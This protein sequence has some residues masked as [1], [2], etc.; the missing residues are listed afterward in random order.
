MTERAITRSTERVSFFHCQRSYE[1]TYIIF[2]IVAAAVVVL[3]TVY[4]RKQRKK[5]QDERARKLRIASGQEVEPEPVKRGRLRSWL[6]P[7]AVAPVVP[8]QLVERI[9]TAVPAAVDETL[10]HWHALHDAADKASAADEAALN[11]EVSGRVGT[12]YEKASA[13]PAGV[14]RNLAGQVL[15]ERRAQR[16]AL[17]QRE[18]YQQEL[19]AL[20]RSQ[21]RLQELLPT[22]YF[23]SML[24]ADLAAMV[25][26]AHLV[27]AE[28]Q[29]PKKHPCDPK[30]LR[31]LREPTESDSDAEL[32][33][34]LVMEAALDLSGAVHVLRQADLAVSA[35]YH[36]LVEARGEPALDQPDKP[37]DAEVQTWLNAALDWS[38]QSF[39]LEQPFVEGVAQLRS[40]MANAELR[41]QTLDSLA[42]AAGRLA[43]SRVEAQ[44]QA[45]A[46]AEPLTGQPAD[47]ALPPAP[48]PVKR[49]VEL[50]ELLTD[51]QWAQL[52]VAQGLM[53]YCT[54]WT[55]NIK[56]QLDA[57]WAKVPLHPFHQAEM[58]AAVAD[59]GGVTQIRAAMR[60]LGFAAAQLNSA[61]QK[62]AT[63]E[64]REPEAVELDP[65]SLDEVNVE[66]YV[67]SHRRWC[68]DQIA[69]ATAVEA[70]SKRI[71]S[72]GQQ[73]VERGSQVANAASALS[74]LLQQQPASLEQAVV[75]RAARAMVQQ[76][77]AQEE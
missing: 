53:A 3:G 62:L 60:K 41:N 77:E 26:A 19:S 65:P 52:H 1:M 67:R 15:K 5:L 31:P 6:A 69:N 72:Y 57:G 43:S 61:Q 30:F 14:L 2:I 51:N 40:A 58:P 73:A 74:S 20:G 27:L 4:V 18:R 36:R 70:R 21:Q 11:A 68:K 39:E 10:Q 45:A 71:E 75:L 7:K 32:S 63:E 25:R 49:E 76:A 38:R 56:T 50:V 16:E 54:T 59:C 29:H 48:V 33:L 66:M 42:A 23:A 44:R 47:V 46:G 22:S 35:R 64:A 17:L 24:P 8:P 28:C 9:K 34:K 12:S 55:S 13:D 37:N